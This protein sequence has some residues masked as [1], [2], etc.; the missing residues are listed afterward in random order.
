MLKKNQVQQGINYD[1]KL[2]LQPSSG[3]I[4]LTGATM[5]SSTL[6]A[7]GAVNANGNS[8][9]FL[10]ALSDF[11][12]TSLSCWGF[13]IQSGR[14]KS[15]QQQAGVLRNQFVRRGNPIQAVLPFPTRWR[16]VGS[17]VEPDR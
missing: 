7:S 5:C 11:I 4:T 8:L 3:T 15:G 9:S 12:I 2:N 10:N 1:K 13:G 17:A 14:L 16:H 6:K